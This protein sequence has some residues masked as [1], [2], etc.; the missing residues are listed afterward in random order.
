MTHII[1][2][3]EIDSWNSE[4][5]LFYNETLAEM[6]GKKPNDKF[7]M[8]D[9]FRAQEIIREQNFYKIALIALD[10]ILNYCDIN[11]MCSDCIFY[12]SDKQE[13]TIHVS[14]LSNYQ[15]RMKESEE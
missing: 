10:Y 8:H 12:D 6:L 9:W 1:I 3:I 11:D 13:C 7:S 5:D 2:I 15:E 4:L 14:N